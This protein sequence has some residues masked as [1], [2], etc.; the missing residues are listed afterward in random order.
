MAPKKKKQGAQWP[1]SPID[2][3]NQLPFYGNYASIIS[4]TDLLH[5][6]QIGVLPSKELTHEFMVFVPL[7]IWRLGLPVSPFFPWPP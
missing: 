5:L 6:V 7:L 4:E 1:S 3:N 2:P